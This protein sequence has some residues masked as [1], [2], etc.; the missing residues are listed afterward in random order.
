MKRHLTDTL[1]CYYCGSTDLLHY[2]NLSDE[3]ICSDCVE[4]ENKQFDEE[5]ENREYIGEPI[6]EHN[7]IERIKP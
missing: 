2:D 1:S 4:S 6:F 7:S 5:E 3:Y